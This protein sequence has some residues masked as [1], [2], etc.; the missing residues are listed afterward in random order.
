[1]PKSIP[2]TPYNY[3]AAAFFNKNTCQ[4]QKEVLLCMCVRMRVCACV[5][6]RA[7]IFLCLHIIWINTHRKETLKRLT[8]CSMQTTCTIFSVNST[9]FSISA[10][11]QLFQH[12]SLC[13]SLSLPQDMAPLFC[14]LSGDYQ[15]VAPLCCP[16]FIVPVFFF[17]LPMKAFKPDLCALEKSC[18]R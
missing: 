6:Q 9:I 2:I 4:S 15:S 10:S 13:L 16:S 5:R 3:R 12:F 18:Y 14:L 7:C 11:K 8:N 17:L 1:M